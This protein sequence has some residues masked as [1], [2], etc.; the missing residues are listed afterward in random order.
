MRL[1]ECLKCSL[2]L[3]DLLLIL[4]ATVQLVLY[5]HGV[6]LVD[7]SQV[8]NPEVSILPQHHAEVCQLV[9]L[10]HGPDDLACEVM[11]SRTS[12]LLVSIPGVKLCHDLRK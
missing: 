10:G 7:G 4:V 5:H 6:G 12:T 2:E 3:K 11:T 8:V 9:R 1:V